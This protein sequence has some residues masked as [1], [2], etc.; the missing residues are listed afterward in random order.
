MDT[1]TIMNWLQ[2]KGERLTL[3][4][5]LVIEALGQSHTHQTIKDLQQHINDKNLNHQLSETTIYRVLQWLKEM[6]IISQTDLAQS[7]VVYALTN[8]QY[9]H[10]LVCLKCDNTFTVEDELFASLREE[11]NT[12]Y[13]FEARIE[14]MAI[15]GQCKKCQDELAIQ[16]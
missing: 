8:N 6:G 7:G 3:P 5:R 10:H 13:G 11:L 1:V 16:E 9:H 15:Y 2:K 4:R 12:K 14:H